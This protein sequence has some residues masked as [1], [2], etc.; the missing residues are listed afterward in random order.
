[1]WD[2]RRHAA[3][4][5]R[6][7]AARNGEPGQDRKVAAVSRT[8]RVTWG[9]LPGVG[10]RRKAGRFTSTRGARRFGR[11]A[12]KRAGR[13]VAH[14]CRRSFARASV[15]GET[16]PDRLFHEIRPI[17]P[18]FRSSSERTR[19]LPRRSSRTRDAGSAAAGPCGIRVSAPARGSGQSPGALPR[20]ERQRP[21]GPPPPGSSAFIRRVPNRATP[22]T[23]A[24]FR[25]NGSLFASPSQPRHSEPPP[26]CRRLGAPVRLAG[27]AE[28]LGF[29][30]VTGKP[31][32][33]KRRKN[34]E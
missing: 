8:P 4:M 11:P 21:V 13:S 31:P 28:K 10:E 33:N 14:G 9:R 16:A 5:E 26:G 27:V 2:C 30:T 15:D 24:C 22:H 32:P 1:M 19:A 34:T 12:R 20:R 3:L 29:R 17:E 18:G 23:Y 6:S 7:R 25:P